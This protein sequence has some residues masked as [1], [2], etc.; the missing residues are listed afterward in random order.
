MHQHISQIYFVKPTEIYLVYSED[1]VGWY[2][3][4]TGKSWS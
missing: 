2:A 4:K 3:P 1:R